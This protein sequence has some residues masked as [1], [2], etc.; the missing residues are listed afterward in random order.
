[1]KSFL[2]EDIYIDDDFHQQE[3]PSNLLLFSSIQKSGS[4][5][6]ISKSYVN[7]KLEIINENEEFSENFKHSLITSFNDFSDE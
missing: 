3:L 5:C 4:A 7:R 6:K 1:M 2:Q